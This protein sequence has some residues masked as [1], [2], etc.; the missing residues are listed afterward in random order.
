MLKYMSE[1]HMADFYIR[2]KQDVIDT[3][4]RLGFLPF[5]SNEIK[6]FSIEEN[7]DP[8]V[9]FGEEEGVWD[10]KGPVIQETGC[11]YG[12]FFRNK[13]VFISRKWFPDFANYRRDGYDFDARVDEGIAKYNEQYLYNIIASRH[14]LLSKDAKV[15]GGYVKPRIKGQDQWEPRKGF[16][17]T[18]TRLQMQCYIITSNFEYEMDKDGNFYGWGIARYTTPEEFFGK[19]FTNHVYDRTPEESKKRI[20]RH[21]KKILPGTSEAEIEHLLK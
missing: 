18:I 21:L 14:S 3:V 6:G 4:E 15:I 16:D 1:V 9:Y 20:I 17:T 19:K 7:V 8:R 11:A 12:K 2:T 5:F 13:A 10:W